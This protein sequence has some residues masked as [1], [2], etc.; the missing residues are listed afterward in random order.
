METGNIQNQKQPWSSV[1]DDVVSATFFALEAFLDQ[2]N[3]L[4]CCLFEQAAVG[5]AFLD[6]TDCLVKVNQKFCQLLGYSETDLRQRSFH[7]LV[8]P[9]DLKTWIAEIQNLRLGTR[10]SFSIE[11]RYICQNHHILW[12][13]TTGSSVQEAA[14]PLQFHTVVIQDITE[15]KQAELEMSRSHD[16]FEA[17]FQES[18]DAIFLVDRTTLLIFDCNQRAVVLFEADSKDDLIGISGT[19]LHRHPFSPEDLKQAGE[20]LRRN[21]IWSQEI[22]YRTF[23]GNFFWGNFAAKEIEVAGQHVVLIRLTDISDRKQSERLLQ[24]QAERESLLKQVAFRT[25]ESLNLDYILNTS[26][27]RVQAFLQTDRVVIYRFEPDGSSTIAVE[28]VSQPAFSISDRHLEDLACM[29]DLSRRY[30]Q[31]RTS[32]VSHLQAEEIAAYHQ[33]FLAQIPVKAA[34]VVP[35]L[36]DQQLW[37]LLIAQH[38]TPRE[39]Q[40]FELDLLSQLADQMSIAIW[41]TTLYAQLETELAE[42]RRAEQAL[43]QQVQYEQL[44]QAIS[45]QIRSSLRL[46]EI[47]EAAVTQVRQ[48]LQVDRALVFHLN[49]DGFGQVIKEAVLPEYPVTA[50]MLFPDEQFPAECRAF[51]QQGLPR[52]IADIN[53]DILS[54]CLVSFMHQIQVKSKMVA[55]IVQSYESGEPVVWG[56]LIVHACADYRQ[57]QPAEVGLLQQVA[58]QMGIAIQQSDLYVELENQLKQKEILFK[59]VHHR[60]KNNLQVIS[61][62]LKLQ[63][64]ATQDAAILDVLED[65]RNRLRAIAL[66]HEILYQSNNLE[67]LAFHHYI[68]QLANTILATH[69]PR[70][71]IR[72]TYQLQPVLLNL[73]TAFPCGLLLSELVTNAIKHAFP[74]G[75][76]GEIRI[77][78]QTVEDSSSGSDPPHVKTT[79]SVSP[80]AIVEE[81]PNQPR[82]YL[83]TVQDNGIGMPADLDVSNLK[84]LG[85]KI[86]YDLTLQLRG[87]LKLEQA[88]GTRFQLTFS[89]LKYHKRF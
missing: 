84:S 32:A 8:H 37:G 25:R 33:D 75:R 20:T 35:I 85:L 31:G 21:G 73:E 48:L 51:Y 16:L 76:Q 82:K 52:M 70:H 68:Q 17:L 83:L 63:A 26:V 86:A 3:P 9:D 49:A 87:V 53:Q 66:I 36:Q 61:A 1:T 47:L 42:R 77:A 12:A 2:N 41:Q 10:P 29:V 30:Q 22:E 14:G 50:E 81:K 34:M 39:W 13:T 79:N 67:H 6:V 19:T 59:E 71:Q 18:A 74:N 58:V 24:R 11:Q 4:F 27:N 72:L 40:T 46:E 60:V 78:L 54:E 7:S 57:W 62:M 28:V 65:S 15:R 44:L 80:S 88:Q 89:E 38:C 64:R 5:I 56:L 23:K 45:Q 43:A 55:P 69:S